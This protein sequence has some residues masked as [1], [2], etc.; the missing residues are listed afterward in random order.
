MLVSTWCSIID[1]EINLQDKE[2][3]DGT[4]SVVIIV[5]ELLRRADPTIKP[6]PYPTSKPT[7]NN[8][9][10]FCG[11]AEPTPPQIAPKNNDNNYV[12]FSGSADPPPPPITP[13]NDDN[14]YGI[15]CGSA[16]PTPPPNYT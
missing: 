15:F 14:N 12:I 2:V 3:G 8:Y 11:S 9:G 1:A 5:A 6:T 7:Y 16:E 4:T 10:I 13:K